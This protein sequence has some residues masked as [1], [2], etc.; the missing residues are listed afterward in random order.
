MN[1]KL[2]YA[3]HQL[4]NPRTR[5][6]FYEDMAAALKDGMDIVT[7][8]S[9]RAARAARMRDP[10]G[11]LYRLWIKRMDRLSFGNAVVGTLPTNEA[12]VIMAAETGAELPD[13]MLFLAGM[14]R[15]VAQMKRAVRAA[16]AVPAIVFTVI[17][18]LV[19]GFSTYFVPVL[20]QIVPPEKWPSSGQLLKSIADFTVNYGALALIAI[21][22]AVAG[23][24]WSLNN[25]LGPQRRILDNLPPWNIFRAYTG[26][27]SL[28]SMSAL[29]QSG[30]S[31][32]DTLEK[33][34]KGSKGWLRWQMRSIIRRLDVYSGEPGKA[35]DTGL[36]P[37]QILNRVADRSQRSDFGEALKSIGLT[38][39]RDVQTDLEQT[40][41]WLNTVMVVLAAL[42]LGVLIVGFLETTYSIQSSM[43]KI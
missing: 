27:I 15:S 9:S 20:A 8:L 38:V 41:K 42:T 43:R 36:L 14:V 40:T 23:F 16:M 13:N 4:A 31:L 5:A 25:V 12:A 29:M 19:Y 24:V 33:I 7:Y 1:Y 28:V 34:A 21:A 18:G 22:G 11:P 3:K 2:L 35:F 6:S 10:L 30:M 39:V 37:L 17:C 26:A 32:V